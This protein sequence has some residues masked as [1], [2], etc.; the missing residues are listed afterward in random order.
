LV[1]DIADALHPAEESAQEVSFELD[2]FT[3]VGADRLELS[4]RWFGVRGRRFVRPMLTLR[5]G[6]TSERSL[7]D[8]EHKPWA[9]EDGEEWRAA[10]PL[11]VDAAELEAVELAVSPDITLSLPLPAG[12]G[13]K[14]RSPRR[15]RAKPRPEAGDDA[16]RAEAEGLRARLADAEATLKRDR[17]ENA[18]LQQSLSVARDRIEELAGAEARIEELTE[19][20]AGL[21]GELERYHEELEQVHAEHEQL[22]SELE[23][24]SEE[25][26]RGREERSA[27]ISERDRMD[28]V[29]DRLRAERDRLRVA[30]ERLQADRE[31]LQAERDQL[32]AT[33]DELR[34]ER[35]QLRSAGDELRSGREQLA[36]A[37][38]EPRVSDHRPRAAAHPPRY[39]PPRR[40][41][42]RKANWAG[43]VLAVV[44]FLAVIAALL[45]LVHPS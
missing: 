45:V 2:E 30:L 33:S 6:E 15:S 24:L 23:R 7:A 28:P 22:Q 20:R 31:K 4:G 42:R 37:E 43:R 25:R 9:P 3:L 35:D 34:G 11:D 13:G 40:K 39:E 12:T 29:L 27:L 41:R 26:A 44:V 19:E 21:K 36:D 16:L 18:E 5:L 10:F 1:A 8:L 17:V 38:H 32:R 14:R